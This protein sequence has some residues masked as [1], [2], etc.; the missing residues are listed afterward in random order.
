MGVVARMHIRATTLIA[1]DEVACP[2]PS[3]GK[4]NACAVSTRRIPLAGGGRKSLGLKRL[5]S[6]AA[7]GPLR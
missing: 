6:A 5:E 3:V 4:V 1:G 7:P 2:G